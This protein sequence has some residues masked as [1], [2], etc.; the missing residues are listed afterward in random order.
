MKNILITGENSYIG[1]NFKNFISTDSD[2]YNVEVISVRG[3]EWTQKDF[4]NIDTIVHVA[5]I[6][7][8][9]NVDKDIYYS[10]NTKLPEEIAKKAKREGVN[11]FIYFSSMSIFGKE[12]GQ[13]DW[14]TPYNPKNYYGKSKLKAEKALKKLESP[15]F[16]IVI[17]RPPMVYGKEAPGNYQKLLKISKFLRFFPDSNNKRSMINID[18]LSMFLKCLIDNNSRGIY[19]P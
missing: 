3:K 18:L 4:T 8:K 9:K 1:N 14:T 10:I 19:H 12:N 17:L 5:G 15:L 13:I 11:Q 2:N 7:H 16:N 6:V